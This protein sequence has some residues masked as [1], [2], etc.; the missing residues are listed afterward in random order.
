[1][2]AVHCSGEEC[3]RCASFKMKWSTTQVCA[4]SLSS[5]L[6]KRVFYCKSLFTARERP[7]RDPH[8]NRGQHNRGESIT[9][10]HLIIHHFSSTFLCLLFF[11]FFCGD[12]AWTHSKL[13]APWG[14]TKFRHVRPFAFECHVVAVKCRGVQLKASAPNVLPWFQSNQLYCEV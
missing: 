8:F 9:L 14:R 11:F 10:S 13:L 3:R 5:S 1:M 4:L 12:D 2:N 6:V 7:S